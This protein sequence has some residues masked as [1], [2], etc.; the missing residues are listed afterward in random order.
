MLCN[1]MLCYVMLCCVVLCYVMLCYRNLNRFLDIGLLKGDTKEAATTEGMARL[2][3]SEDSWESVD[4]A[5]SDDAAAKPT[6]EA[7]D[8]DWVPEQDYLALV[9]K[10]YNPAGCSLKSSTVALSAATFSGYIAT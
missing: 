6:A 7:L 8:A 4:K 9:C 3:V 1:V 10:R 2:A 5:A